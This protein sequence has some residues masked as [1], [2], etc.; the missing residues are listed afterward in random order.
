[1]AVAVKVS[2]LPV[3]AAPRLRA[4]AVGTHWGM[5]G[6]AQGDTHGLNVLTPHGAHL[7]A[8]GTG[9]KGETWTLYPK[10]R[11]KETGKIFVTY[12]CSYKS[13]Q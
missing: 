8:M 12:S 6:K 9:P 10:G 7:W 13:M 2:S 11:R 4:S 1:M 5:S 3:Q